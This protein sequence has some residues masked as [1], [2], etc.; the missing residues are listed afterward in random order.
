M[1]QKDICPHCKQTIKS[2]QIDLLK[3]LKYKPLSNVDGK[4][5]ITSCGKVYSYKRDNFVKIIN[6]RVALLQNSNLKSFKVSNLVAEHF[7]P[8][9][10]DIKDPFVMHIDDNKDNNNIDNLKV[11]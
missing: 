7:Y 6:R 3:D 9:Y 5:A 10:K 2:P 1:K 4:Y 8:N 11:I